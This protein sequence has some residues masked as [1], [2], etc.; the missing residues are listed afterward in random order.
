MALQ[1][2]RLKWEETSARDFLKL[3]KENFPHKCFQ[4]LLT[5][6]KCTPPLQMISRWEQREENNNVTRNASRSDYLTLL[7]LLKADAKLAVVLKVPSL[8]KVEVRNFSLLNF[9]RWLCLI[10]EHLVMSLRRVKRSIICK[11]Q[12]FCLFNIQKWSV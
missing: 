10:N 6:Y 3:S 2:C 4:I 7:T 8:T 5:S 9:P 11:C 12:W 1:N